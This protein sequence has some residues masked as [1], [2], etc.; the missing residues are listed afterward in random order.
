MIKLSRDFTPTYLNPNKVIELT[1]LF[2]DTS[3]SVWNTPEI[4]ESL[5]ALSND[6]CAYCE[7]KLNY[8]SNYLEVEHFE[9]KSHYPEKVV[10]WE[11][12]LP[13]CKRCN[14]SKG[15]HNVNDEP[16]I[17][18]FVEDPKIHL[19]LRCYRLKG[20]T[21]LGQATIDVID[22]NNSARSVYK[23]FEIGNAILETLEDI[24]YKIG[25]YR[26]KQS[27]R[28]K[29]KILGSTEALLLECQPTAAYTATSASVLHSNS[30]Y[31][32]IRN[33]LKSLE[34]WAQELEELHN[35]SKR[36]VLDFI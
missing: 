13:S 2:V 20:K 11:N 25:C 31:V 36:F 15:F 19:R 17:N 14:G 6:K 34:I 10:V 9:D 28:M 23:R 4:K 35:N 7:C 3:K 1:S 33:T 21:T 30:D 18:P 32:E 27:T 5:L 12:L 8:E 24:K 16:I 22:L 26:E 29:N